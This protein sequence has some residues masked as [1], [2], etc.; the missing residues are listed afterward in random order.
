MG[1]KRCQL[2]CTRTF[3]SI[4]VWKRFFKG[5]ANKIQ[6]KKKRER[7]TETKTSTAGFKMLHSCLEVI[8]P[9]HFIT[10]YSIIQQIC[11]IVWV[12]FVCLFCNS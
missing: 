9:A 4:K 3:E 6:K 7:N 2:R 8:I 1:N 5:N 11:S 10:V 12:E